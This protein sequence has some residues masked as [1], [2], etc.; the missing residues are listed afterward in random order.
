MAGLGAKRA[1]GDDGGF[2]VA[3]R[4]L[5]KR[6]FGQIPVNRSEILE[7]EF[8]GAE[9]GVAQPGFF[10]GKFLLTPPAEMAAGIS[11]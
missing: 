4:V 10:H 6:R 2:A 7:T 1:A 8:V 11:T 3:D 5:V 9:S